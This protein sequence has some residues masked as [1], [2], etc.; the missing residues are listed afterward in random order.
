[1]AT[2]PPGIPTATN[3]THKLGEN[4]KVCLLVFDCLNKCWFLFL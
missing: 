1:M 4:D 2:P 3:G